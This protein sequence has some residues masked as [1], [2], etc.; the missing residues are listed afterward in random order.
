M[1]RICLFVFIATLV[2]GGLPLPVSALSAD[3]VTAESACLIDA[4]TGQVLFGKD[5]HTRRHPASTTKVMTGLLVMEQFSPTD[6]LTVSADAVQIPYNSSHVALAPGE[7]LSID[8][9]MY[10]LMLPSANDAANA[11]AEHAAGSVE[12]FAERMTQRARELGA[13]NTTFTNPHG[14]PDERHLT[15][16]YDLSVITQAAIKNPAFLTYFGTA[17]HTMPPTN[18]QEQERPFTNQMYM[19]LPDMEWCYNPA[20]IG[21]KTGYTDEARH[22]MTSAAKQ[23]GRTLVATVLGCGIDQKFDDTQLLF[24]YGFDAFHQV[25]I[26]PSKLEGLSVP[27]VQE[28][29]TV[30]EATFT[31]AAG[32]TILLPNGME[33]DAIQYRYNL[34]STVEKDSGET[35]ASVTLTVEG[36]PDLVMELPLTAAHELHAVPVSAPQPES[37]TSLVQP[38]QAFVLRTLQK[39]WPVLLV[40]PAALLL[41]L[42]HR[43]RRIRRRARRRLAQRERILWQYKQE[44][45]RAASSPRSSYSQT[46]QRDRF[47]R[48]S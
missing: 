10:A 36:M 30:G 8:S 7:E 2:I 37:A 26:P 48:S 46:Y 47:R 23:Q 19:L 3:E 44:R 25:A 13:R 21:G 27:I 31:A 11:L 22:T 9:A 38:L 39:Y 14:L 12:N 15:T 34:P 24:D 17:R 29:E 33:A 16:A 42:L 45:H 28:G 40:L 18:L 43:Y 1:K 20:V 32:A 5:A 41:L 4:D 35:G 6:R